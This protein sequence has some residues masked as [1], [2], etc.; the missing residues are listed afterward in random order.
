M[1][2]KIIIILLLYLFTLSSYGQINI[3]K[4]YFPIWT[5]HQDSI[6]IH[7]FS[8]GLLSLNTNPR[9][10]NT[11][12]IKFE[13]IGIGFLAAPFMP[14]SPI[15]YSDSSLNELLKI[16]ISENINGLNLSTT[17]S[18][19][20]CYTNGISAGIILQYQT[21]VNGVSTSIFNLIQIQNGI[22]VGIIN[23]T[24]ILNG[25]Q[26]GLYN[27]SENLFGIQIGLWNEN[28]KRK[29]PFIN[30]NFESE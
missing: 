22:M 10:T 11:N 5:Y 23:E 6:N 9:Y 20:N 14:Q 3:N 30:W 8:L 7:G 15:V 2:Y 16:P 17:G 27:I 13:L 21:Q 29:L 12:G 26:I 19:C 4:D 1:K 18:I 28:Q 25:L 24:Y